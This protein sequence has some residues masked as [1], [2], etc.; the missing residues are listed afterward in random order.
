LKRF[1]INRF[2]SGEIVNTATVDAE[3]DKNQ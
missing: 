3:S 2:G 1:R